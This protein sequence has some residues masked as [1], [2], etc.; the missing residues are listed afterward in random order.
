MET[1]GVDMAEPPKGL[2]LAERVGLVDLDR[3]GNAM[4]VRQT[5]LFEYALGEGAGDPDFVAKAQHLLLVQERMFV[6]AAFVL[7][8]W[9]LPREADDVVCFLEDP[10][11]L[12]RA[13]NHMHVTPTILR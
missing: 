7:E 8:D 5:M 13:K 1:L 11:L 12:R 4:D 6:L 3:R 10:D 2:V 9:E